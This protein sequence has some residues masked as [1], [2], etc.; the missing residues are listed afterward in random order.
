MA[1]SAAKLEA[2]RRNAQNRTGPRTLE[3]KKKS[4]L[5][6]LEHGSRAMTLVLPEE[7]P[8]VLEARHAAWSARFLPRSKPVA[9]Y[10]QDVVVSL[11]MLDGARR[12]Q[13]A[14]RT[15]NLLEYGVERDTA[16]ANEVAEL[17]RRLFKDRMGPLAFYPC[18][19]LGRSFAFDRKPSTSFGADGE[20]PDPPADL[21]LGLQSTEY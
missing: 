16:I 3:G 8:Q 13:T 20:D 5:N 9:W 15:T 14:R 10:L 19:R 17:G 1:V 11:W 7:E 12:A 18:S 6:T 2:N 21:V 4:I